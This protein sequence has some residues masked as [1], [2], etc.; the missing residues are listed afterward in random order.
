MLIRL[1]P[2]NKFFVRSN[3]NHITRSALFI[4][5][6]IHTAEQARPAEWRDEGNIK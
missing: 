3:L 2:Q 4:S 1:Q 6:H 5:S